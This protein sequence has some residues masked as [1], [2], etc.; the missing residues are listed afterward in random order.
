MDR[1]TLERH[2]AMAERHV[3]EGEGHVA[4]QRELVSKLIRE[5]HQDMI[6]EA[7]R[8]LALLEEMQALHAS[9]KDRLRAQLTETK[10]T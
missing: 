2:L 3:A 4:R 5:G 8:F 9:D 6:P 10:N 7:K 1:S